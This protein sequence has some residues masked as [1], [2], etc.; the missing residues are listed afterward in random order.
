MEGPDTKVVCPEADSAGLWVI[1]A[2]VS[3]FSTG[4][5]RVEEL[6]MHVLS[7]MEMRGFGARLSVMK[8]C[9]KLS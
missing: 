9:R 3:A 1:L 7:L 8:G 5:L 4:L 6:G 2:G